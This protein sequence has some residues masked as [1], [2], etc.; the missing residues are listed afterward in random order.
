MTEEIYRRLAQRLDSLPNG[1]P[2]TVDGAELR[3]LE[4]LFH[5]ACLLRL[6][7]SP[8]CKRQSELSEKTDC[9]SKHIS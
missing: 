2:S 8:Y 7:L 6:F 1:F 5:F 4:K 9:Y 3:L